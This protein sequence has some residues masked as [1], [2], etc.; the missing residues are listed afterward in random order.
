ME[1]TL[2]NKL[3]LTELQFSLVAIKSFRITEI[4]GNKIRGSIGRIMHAPYHTK[5]VTIQKGEMLS[6]SVTIFG[7]A[8]AGGN[9]L[10]LQLRQR[11]KITQKHGTPSLRG[12]K[13]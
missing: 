7:V 6:F 13:L 1:D 11:S 5:P 10:P 12:R 4:I 3:R 9:R 2:L 8:F